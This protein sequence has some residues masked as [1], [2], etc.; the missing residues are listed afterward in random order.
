M[1]LVDKTKK[2]SRT[3]ISALFMLSCLSLKA[4][5]IQISPEFPGF[6]DPI[7]ANNPAVMDDM[8]QLPYFPGSVPY[9]RLITGT[10][11]FLIFPGVKVNPCNDDIVVVTM[12]L[13]QF[14]DSSSPRVFNRLTPARLERISRDGGLTWGKTYFQM[15]APIALGGT[16]SQVV[17]STGAVYDKCGVVV[18]SGVFQDTHINPPRSFPQSGVFFSRSQ[19]NGKTWSTPQV[20]ATA[21]SN[22]FAQVTGTYISASSIFAQ[23]EDCNL[24]HMIYFPNTFPNPVAGD[25]F[26]T[27]STNGGK[28]WSAGYQIY[29]TL[30]D[31]VWLMNHFNP[32]LKVAGQSFPAELIAYDEN[33]LLLPIHRQ[34]PKVNALIFDRSVTTTNW[35]K[36]VVRSFDKGITWDPVAG[37]TE[38]FIDPFAHDPAGNKAPLWTGNRIFSGDLATPIVSSPYTGRVY[39]S[40]MAGNTDISADPLVSQ[41]YPRIVLVASN[42][43]GAT[44]TS[45]VQVNQTPTNIPIDAQQAFWNSMTIGN[46]GSVVIVYYDFRN[47]QGGT[48]LDPIPT[49][50]WMDIYKEVADPNGGS[51]GVGLDFFKEVRLTPN[52]YNARISLTAGVGTRFVVGLLGFGS[53]VTVNQ[54]N[55]ALAV[56][57]IAYPSPL[58]TN[59]GYKGMT[60]NTNNF[61]TLFLQKVQLPRPSNE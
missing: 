36:A 12:N 17:S 47:W 42:D 9:L 31:P 24:L 57:G 13:D 41:G 46:D 4:D 59:I 60:E 18:G 23:P 33:L 1:N 22:A 52:S 54:K 26:Y 29:S 8:Y 30:T 48:T 14:Q 56:F 55:E 51:T 27:R 49:D 61:S 50:V 39:M 6:V 10:Y 28:T 3:V 11:N 15:Q 58:I 2:N 53:A 5:P 45:P 21:N 20:L 43:K 35:D 19:N 34:Y 44:W 40:Y 37:A 7:L 38:Q 16:L 25:P 32:V